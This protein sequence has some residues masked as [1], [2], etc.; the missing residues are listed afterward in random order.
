MVHTA[1]I[2]ELVLYTTYNLHQRYLICCQI[3]KNKQ[4][5]PVT[6]CWLVAEFPFFNPIL[7]DLFLVWMLW[8]SAV[9]WLHSQSGISELPCLRSQWFV[10]NIKCC[11]QCLCSE[12]TKL[13]TY[14]ILLQVSA[15]LWM[16]YDFQP[17]H[18]NYNTSENG[19][20]FLLDHCQIE[21]TAVTSFETVAT[22]ELHP[23]GAEGQIPLGIVLGLLQV[24]TVFIRCLFSL[25]PFP[26]M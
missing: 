24:A 22:E 17:E 13:P 18:G 1:T 14:R 3:A 11:S 19:V 7:P 16:H 26:V 8:C 2:S 6:F 25:S 12:A 5:L 15:P 21:V 4:Q 10:W 20:S 23:S 9:S